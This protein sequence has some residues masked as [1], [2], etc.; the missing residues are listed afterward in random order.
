MRKYIVIAFALLVSLTLL[1]TLSNPSQAVQTQNLYTK[2]DVSSLT[3]VTY[4]IRGC[5]D[6]TGIADVEAIA[7]ELQQIQPDIIALQ[8]VDEGLPR[9]GFVHQT[10]E[11]AHLLKMNY[12][13]SPTVDFVIGQFGNA[14]LSKYK[15]NSVQSFKLPSRFE[16]RGVMRVEI[17]MGGQP[18]TV[19]ATHLGL[20]HSERKKQL[21]TLYS[22]LKKEEPRHATILL[23][24]FNTDQDDP[25]LVP[26]RRLLIDP[27]FQQHERIVTI[28]GKANRGIDHIFVSRDFALS[29]ATTMT[30]SRSDHNPVCFHL[31]ISNHKNL[32]QY[33]KRSR[34]A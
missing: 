19:F 15:I 4:N 27:L 20:A 13:F 29:Y 23:G 8:E 31:K 34:K 25:L 28:E 10:E 12:A 18:L 6:E 1:S 11:L 5:R 22:Y 21:Q 30:N 33:Q 9:S 32:P 14:V 16:P 7:Q 26:L 17:D 2:K 3:A 24:D